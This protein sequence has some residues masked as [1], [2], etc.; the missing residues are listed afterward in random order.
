MTGV[1]RAP[2]R[3]AQCIGVAAVLDSEAEDRKICKAADAARFNSLH[4]RNTGMVIAAA[5]RSQH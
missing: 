2:P 5:R 3:A 1:G 4:G